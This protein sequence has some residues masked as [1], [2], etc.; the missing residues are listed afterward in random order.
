[1][2]FSE[3]SLSQNI[4]KSIEDAGFTECTEVQTETLRLTL[5]GKDVFV[6]SQTGTG[7]T[8]AFLI[9]LF[10]LIESKIPHVEAPRSLGDYGA[11]PTAEH[12]KA[13]L[14][15]GVEVYRMDDMIAGNV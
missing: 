1:M 14:P 12:I 2:Q 13:D 9:S 10:E 11:L 7:K 8:A 5:S 4:L 15:G 6:Q 3:F